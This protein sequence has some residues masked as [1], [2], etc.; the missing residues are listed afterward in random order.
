MP[1]HKHIELENAIENKK[2]WNDKVKELKIEVKKV[3][4]R[5]DIINI[6]KKNKRNMSLREISKSMMNL[7]GIQISHTGVSNIINE[8]I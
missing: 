4:I 3:V 5:N 1:V 2:Y 6:M 7:H 8:V